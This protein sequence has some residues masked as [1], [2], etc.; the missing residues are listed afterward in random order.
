MS[1][2]VQ[3]M[4]VTHNKAPMDMAY[5]LC[6]ATTREPGVSRLVQVDLAEA[7]KLAGLAA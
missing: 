7:A 4:V 2:K 3:F 1:G 6:G 5:Q